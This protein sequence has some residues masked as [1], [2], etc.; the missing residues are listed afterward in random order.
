MF[1][2][3]SINYVIE[4]II[5]FYFSFFRQE[6]LES[7]HIYLKIRN[8]TSIKFM[9]FLVRQKNREKTIDISVCAKANLID[10]S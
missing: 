10:L 1:F 4:T 6:E 3:R 9:N 2:V 8:W 5:F 7:T